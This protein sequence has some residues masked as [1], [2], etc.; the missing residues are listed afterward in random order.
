MASGWV[1]GGRLIDRRGRKLDGG[2][3]TELVLR[4]RNAGYELW[5]EPSLV[6]SHHISARRMSLRHVCGLNRGFGRSYP[7]FERLV[8]GAETP[9]G[10]KVGSIVRNATDV[11]R[12]AVDVIYPRSNGRLS[13]RDAAIELSWAVGRVEGEL[14]LLLARHRR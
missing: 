12:L 14:G 4:I 11:C 9:W 3:D 7:L 2:G 5:Y 8:H 13:R 1:E 10:P 6:L